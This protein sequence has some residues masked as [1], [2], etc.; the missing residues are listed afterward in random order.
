MLLGTLVALVVTMG[1]CASA[2]AS[3][4]PAASPS[5]SI[6]ANPVTTP[7]EAA[8]RVMAEEPMLAGIGKKDPD[9]IGACCFYEAQAVDGGYQ[10]RFEVGWGDCPSGCINKHRWSYAV[11]PDGLVELLEESGAS[12]EPGVLPGDN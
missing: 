10:V 9:L 1:A 2:G 7:D 11:N 5:P 8:E 3:A 6:A 12:L 4:P